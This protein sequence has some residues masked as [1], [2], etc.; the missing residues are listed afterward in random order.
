MTHHQF[1]ASDRR[2]LPGSSRSL[3]PSLPENRTDSSDQVFRDA[4]DSAGPRRDLRRR[5]P[6]PIRH[7]RGLEPAVV[8]LVLGLV[9]G[10][11]PLLVRFWKEAAAMF[12]RPPRAVGTTVADSDHGKRRGQGARPPGLRPLGKR[13]KSAD[14]AH[15][16]S[17]AA[18][19]YVGLAAAVFSPSPVSARALAAAPPPGLPLSARPGNAAGHCWG[20]RWGCRRGP[21]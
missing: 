1:F 19:A 17:V 3:G 9:V 15:A 2:D 13:R 18:G 4:P 10:R 14:R 6:T 8:D 16:D 20:A 7:P 11:M 21:C 12:A 5:D